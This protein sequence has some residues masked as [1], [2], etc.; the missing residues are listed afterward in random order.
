[1]TLNGDW[2][3]ASPI[4]AKVRITP[5]FDLELGHTKIGHMD[6]GDLVAVPFTVKPGAT[7]T[8]TN[9]KGRGSK[10]CPPRTSRIVE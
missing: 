1:M 10:S 6:E 4:S 5:T 2:T 3:N 7:V 9:G 8:D